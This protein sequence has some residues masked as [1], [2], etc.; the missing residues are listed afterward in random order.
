MIVIGALKVL[1]Y[2]THYTEIFPANQD[3]KLCEGRKVID[4]DRTMTFAGWNF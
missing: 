4:T 1:I 2:R 3:I